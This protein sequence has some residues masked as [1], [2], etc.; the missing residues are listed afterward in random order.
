MR[1]GRY[2]MAA[3]GLGVLAAG[4]GTQVARTASL[5]AAVTRTAGQTARISQTT[6]MRSPG[7]SMSF[8]ATGAFDF[9]R[10]RGTLSMAAP[11][12][13]TEI[14]IPPTTYLKVP[15]GA[16]APLPHG[17]SWVAINAGTAG[18]IG[19][20]FGPFGGQ[21]SNSGDLLSSLTAISTGVTKLGTAT[22]RGVQ[23]TGY[24][25]SVDPAKAAARL[26]SAKRAG[27]RDF[28]SIL[29]NGSIP[30]DVW[31]DGQNLVRQV[32]VTLH[33]PGGAGTPAR[34]QFVQTTDFSDFGAPVHVT[35]PPAAQVASLPQLMKGGSLGGGV[36]GSPNPPKVSGTISPAQSAAAGQVVGAFWAAL[37]KHD[38]GAVAQTVPASQRACIRSFMSGGPKIT[39]TSF[40]LVSVQPAGTGRATARFRVDAHASIG[41]HDI[42]ANPGSGSTQWLVARETGG[43]W[44]VDLAGNSNFIFGGPCG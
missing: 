14:F 30:V 1:G 31:V 7:M 43:H 38:A 39:A 12:G 23:V 6:T 22:I 29:G 4:C 27:F 10:S 44:Y 8:T 35:A 11:V 28:V 37:G 17:K 15:G 18:G 21:G 36:I 33:L 16:G 3:A 9:A 13:M 34:A 2:L 42:P 20:L 19:S 26:P 32:R 5:T 41:G 40:R 25:V 24:R